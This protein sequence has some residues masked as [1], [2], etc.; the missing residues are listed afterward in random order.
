MAD[1]DGAPPRYSTSTDQTRTTSRT[2]SCSTQTT[3]TTGTMDPG[4]PTTKLLKAALPA[5]PGTYVIQIPKDTIYKVPPPENAKRFEQLTNKNPGGGR[6]RRCCGGGARLW[7]CAS[8]SFFAAFLFLIATAVGVFC[9]VVRPESPRFVIQSA[10]ISGFNSASGPISPRFE[11]AVAA[12]NRN[13]KMEMLYQPDSSAAVYYNGIELAAGS[14]PV[15]EQGTEKST[16]FKT[17]L[18]GEGIVLTG[19]VRRSLS[20]GENRGAVPFRLTAT[21]PVKFR[22]G[23]VKS[24]T[25][26]V[27]VDCE[28][29]VDKLTAK[30]K[31]V[32]QKCDSTAKIW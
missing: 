19:A 23:A 9:L 21:A 32:S 26:T 7:L 6:S 29:T 22:L 13:K 14:I 1:A 5:P 28:L 11:L 10:S 31:T 8:I 16:N 25:V 15:F 30:A 12:Q 4:S 24:W 27:K 18:K 17:V 20:D 2:T 3:T